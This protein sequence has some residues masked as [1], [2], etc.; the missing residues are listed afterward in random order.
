MKP[1]GV[2]DARNRAKFF[3]GQALTGTAQQVDWAEKIRAEKIRGMTAPQAVA[4]CDPSSLL[5]SA[6][7]WIENRDKSP[8]E[9][10]QF[11]AS[12]QAL[13]AAYRLATETQDASGVRRIAEEYNA[14]TATWGLR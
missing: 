8:E 13:L 9:I 7:F 1:Q 11:V 12:S 10:A 6:K 14:L 3:G 2:I 5:K 4:A